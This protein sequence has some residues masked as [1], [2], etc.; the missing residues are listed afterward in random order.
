MAVE[1]SAV[2]IPEERSYL[3]LKIFAGL[4]AL[5]QYWGGDQLDWPP[6]QGSLAVVL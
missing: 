2:C 4:Q 5:S 3:P 6:V 1:V